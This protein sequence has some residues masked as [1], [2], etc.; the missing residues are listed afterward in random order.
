MKKIGGGNLVLFGYWDGIQEFWIQILSL[1]Q[2]FYAPSG[3]SPRPQSKSYLCT[4][5]E[6]FEYREIVS[7]LSQAKDMAGWHLKD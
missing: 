4:S 6:R 7:H 3:K 5:E 1:S 2:A